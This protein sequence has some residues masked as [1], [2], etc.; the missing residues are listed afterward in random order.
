M[1]V[2]IYKY[3]ENYQ[4]DIDISFNIKK[5]IHKESR[6]NESNMN[7]II[8]KYTEIMKKFLLCYEIIKSEM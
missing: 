3:L 7:F 1:I 5:E 4:K 8:E 6:N 2:S